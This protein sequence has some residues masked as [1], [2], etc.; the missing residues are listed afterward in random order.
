M[1]GMWACEL[2]EMLTLNAWDLRAMSC[3]HSK[4]AFASFNIINVYPIDCILHLNRAKIVQIFAS[5]SLDLC[6]KTCL[7]M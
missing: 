7:L 4:L 6:C 3:M 1:Y 2:L 5:Q